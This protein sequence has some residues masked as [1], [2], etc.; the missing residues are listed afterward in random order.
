MKTLIK[1]FLIISLLCS[2]NLFGQ[3]VIV[4]MQKVI[5]E[6][7]QGKAV[8][9]KLKKEAATKEAQMKAQQGELMKLQKEIQALMSNPAANKNTLL[10]KQKEGQQKLMKFQQEAQKFQRSLAAK[11]RQAA[12]KIIEKTQMVIQD[13]V[14]K[15][16]Y[17]LVLNKAAV[18]YISDA[19]NITKNVIHEYN[20]VYK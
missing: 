9:N 1:S 18:I 6:V 4:D 15:N 12:G 20:K 11:E 10:A 19:K 3:T 2:F 8:M 13:L 17:T 7:N 5:T 14:K 16:K